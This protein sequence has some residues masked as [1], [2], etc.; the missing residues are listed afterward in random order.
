MAKRNFQSRVQHVAQGSPVNA[1]NT[2]RPTRQLEARTNYVKE[3]LDAI[4]EGRLLIWRE[5][6][7]DP[8]LEVGQPVFWNDET[9]RFE[10]ALAGV[11]VDAGSGFPVPTA[12][13]D[14]LGLLY[15]K[16]DSTTGTIAAV[17]IAKFTSLAAAIDGDLVP[18]RYYLSAVSEGKL[19][20][21]RPAVTVAVCYVL[22]PLNDCDEDVWA[23]ILPQMRD[24]LEDHIH[25]K[26]ELT[27]Q[28]AG[29]VTP[30]ASLSD[31]HV[32]EDADATLPGWLPA[33]DASFG[34]HAP[35]GAAFG[36]N[37]AAHDALRKVFPPV[38]VDACC[39]FW[40]KGE[41]ALTGASEI[42]VNGLYPLVKIDRYGIWWMS[43]CYGEVPWPKDL[44]N[45][46]SSSSLSVTSE[47]L[48]SDT[49]NCRTDRMRLI[50]AFLHMIFA[51]DK[52]VVTSLA[53]V[54]GEPIEFLN[55]DGDVAATGDLLARLKVE[56][57][58]DDDEAYG[59]QVLKTIINSKLLFGRGW[60]AEGLIAASENIEITSTRQRRLTPGD[61]ATALVHQGIVT[62]DV[63]LE[64]GEREISPQIIRL[65]D[66]LER[67]YKGV[68][69]VG[70]PKDRDSALRMRFNV[71]VGGM[72]ANP[73]FKVRA[74]IFGRGNDGPLCAITAGY[75]RL[76]L[77]VEGTP[78]LI[79]EGDT[80]I[81]FDV[82]TASASLDADSV[83]LV[84]SEE[85]TVA[86]GDTVFVQLSRASDADPA[87]DN[88]V[89]F[90]RTVGIVT[91]GE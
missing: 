59:G 36:Y 16:L 91:A 88:D 19:V 30:P 84:E 41:G 6:A 80:A 73:K 20:A 34:N 35:T 40:D 22:G 57:M 32:I 18:G 25:F 49:V 83:I 87:Y 63:N 48:S 21:Q 70:L 81:T 27:C 89:G 52:T 14:C 37:L 90:V 55:C 24:F 78:T 86:A 68:T 33:D 15:E 54:E 8:D 75:Y 45:T 44:D 65:G 71:P 4:D 67:E 82:P 56:A 76:V 69:Y 64:P 11:E 5:Q 2:S 31:R 61:N 72:S 13:T 51:S 85:F 47:S 46:G 38:P 58:I 79:D 39:M 7:I 42:P 17:G 12:A 26:F 60:V 66:A 53:P 43:N 28:P 23:L 10:K 1:G 3:R 62:L 50:L 29:N 77:P 74:W 9:S